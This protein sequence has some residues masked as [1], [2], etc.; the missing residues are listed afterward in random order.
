MARTDYTAKY[1]TLLVEVEDG[2]ATVTINRPDSRNAIN[3]DLFGDLTTIWDDLSTDRDVR[4][5]LLTGAGKYFSVGGDV[6]AMTSRPGGDVLREGEEHDGA[7]T[8][9]LLT[10]LLDVDKPIITASNGDAI[11][12]AATIALMTDI[13]VASE[14]AR[15]ADT[16]VSRVGL[17]AGDGGAAIW[18]LLV[19][20][21]RAKEFLMRGT[22]LTGSAAAEIGLVNHA[23]PAEQTLPYAREIARELAD[24]ARWA[25]RWTKASVN[26]LLKERLNAV[27]PASAALEMV[28]AQT[29]DH[30]EAARAFA[31]KRKPNYSG[32]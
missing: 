3:A 28:S 24:G 32:R 25:I 17:V 29:D 7:G 11:G 23:V 8:R 22:L 15:I 27:L 13:T 19:G 9:R 30:H 6:K 16:H 21:S 4:V 31:E 12:L 14:T 26:Q 20:I 10:R 18:P 1:Q 5:I 2:V